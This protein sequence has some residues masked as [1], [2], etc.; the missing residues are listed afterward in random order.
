MMRKKKRSLTDLLPVIQISEDLMIL[1]DGRAAI[2][3]ALGGLEMEKHT[4]AVYA[5]TADQLAQFL[6]RL[7]AGAVFQKIDSYDQRPYQ[8]S[9]KGKGLSTRPQS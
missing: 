8:E 9:R 1:R 7:P 5:A 2:G 3:F 6:K 4:G